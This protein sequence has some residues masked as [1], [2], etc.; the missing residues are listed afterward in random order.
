MVMVMLQLLYILLG[1]FIEPIGIMVVTLPIMFPVVVALGFDPY[2]FGVM[3]MV[4]FEIA[5]VTP[6]MG[7]QLYII[8]GI[9]P[10]VPLGDILKGAL[11]FLIAPFVMLVTLYVF[12]Q[13][14][15]WLPSLMWS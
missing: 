8:K 10:E 5:L 4:N 14:A 11:V 2:W 6:P 15:L 12:P 3:I 7:T 13:L 9:V 1:M